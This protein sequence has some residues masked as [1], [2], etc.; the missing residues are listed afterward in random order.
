MLRKTLTDFS[1]SGE[2]WRSRLVEYSD[3]TLAPNWNRSRRTRPATCPEHDPLA[4]RPPDHVRLVREAW[5]HRASVGRGHAGIV[6]AIATAEAHC[7][8][9]A[10]AL[11]ERRARRVHDLAVASPRIQATRVDHLLGASTTR[12]GGLVH[13]PARLS[14]AAELPVS[15]GQTVQT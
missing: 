13:C 2:E 9:T 15:F 12:G 8:D 1:N 11:A 7:R 5:L 6:I 10:E 3:A 14:T 4:S